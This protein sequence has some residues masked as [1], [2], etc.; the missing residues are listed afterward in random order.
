V[1]LA[2]CS[3]V[4]LVFGSM[5]SLGMVLPDIGRQLMADQSQLQWMA[6]GYTLV[7]ADPS[8]IGTPTEPRRRI[9]T[10]SADRSPRGL[11]PTT[12]PAMTSR[13]SPD[14]LLRP[15][16]ELNSLQHDPI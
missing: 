11:P 16:Q 2:M 14:R 15:W 7:L 12:T 4:M 1:L 8:R 6:N 10:T 3:S 13:S 9:T 5:T